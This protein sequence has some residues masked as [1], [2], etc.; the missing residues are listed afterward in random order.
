MPNRDE[1]P[2][3]FSQYQ[4]HH[5]DGNKSNNDVSNLQ[6]VTRRE[7]EEIEGI[8]FNR[9]DDWIGIGNFKIRIPSWITFILLM[10]ILALATAIYMAATT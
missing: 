2:L 9:K 4:V 5:I 1:Y 8:G 10:I 7:H 6:I 3:R